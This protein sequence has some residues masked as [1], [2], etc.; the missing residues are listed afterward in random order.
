MIND[1]A[2]LEREADMMGGRASAGLSAPYSAQ[3]QRAF[4]SD[5][6]D[7]RVHEGGDAAALGALAYTGGSDV[8]VGGGEQLLGHEAAH[9]IQQRQGAVSAFGHLAE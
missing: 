7:V 2:A 8:R 9:V 4:G 5:F 3:I 6:S 1:D